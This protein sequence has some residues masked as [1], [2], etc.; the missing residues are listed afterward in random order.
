MNLQRPRLP[1]LY[2]SSSSGR[3][4]IFFP[5]LFAT[6]AGYARTTYAITLRAQVRHHTVFGRCGCATAAYV[7]LTF[8][9]LLCI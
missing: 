2:V 7:Q 4:I 5:V 1:F 9:V 8:L 6:L 3:L